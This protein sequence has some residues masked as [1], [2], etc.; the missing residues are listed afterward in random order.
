MS[1]YDSVPVSY[2]PSIHPHMVLLAKVFDV[3]KMLVI[4]IGLQL[5]GHTQLSRV[6]SSYSYVMVNQIKIWSCFLMLLPQEATLV[7]G[8][9]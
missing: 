8:V 4:H 9:I 3:Q 5:S 6:I 2:D 7:V 1:T